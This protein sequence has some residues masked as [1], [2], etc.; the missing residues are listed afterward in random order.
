MADRTPNGGKSGTQ[1]NTIASELDREVHRSH[2]NR[3]REEVEEVGLDAETADHAAQNT[4]YAGYDSPEFESGDRVSN[5]GGEGP[6]D[7]TLV[8]EDVDARETDIDPVGYVP[9]DHARRGGEL[10]S[11]AGAEAQRASAGRDGQPT[12]GEAPATTSDTPTNGAAGAPGAQNADPAFVPGTGTEP[13]LFLVPT[14]AGNGSNQESSATPANGTDS[15][16]DSE[17][18]S[19]NGGGLVVRDADYEISESSADGA[20]VGAVVA[21][22]GAGPGQVTFGLADDADGRF[23]IDPVSGQVFV[24]D[25][26]LLDYEASDSHEIVVIASLPDGSSTSASFEVRITDDTSESSVSEISDVDTGSNTIGENAAPGTSTGIVVGAVDGDLSDSIEYGLSDDADGAFT[27]DPESG[28]IFVADPSLIDAE[29][30]PTV[31]IEVT[32]TSSDGS[33]TSRTFEIAVEDENEFD[34]TPVVDSGAAPNEIAETASAGDPVGVTGVATDAD[35]TDSN[36]TYSLTE[37]PNDA[38]AIDAETGE[39]TVAD[40]SGLDF[41]SAQSMQIEVTATSEDGSTSSQTFDIAVTD[42]NEFDVSAVTDSDVAADSVSESA[43]AGDSVGVTAFAADADGSNDGVT[44]S[45]SENP[46]DAFAIDADTGEVTVADP[47]GLDFES[48]QSMQIEVTATSEDG[49]SSTQSFDIAVTDSNEFDVSAVSDGD[50]AANSV[51]ENAEA[52]DSVGVTAFASDNDGSSNGVTYSLSENPND[53]FAIDS[54]TGEV[55]VAD[56]SGLDF[57]SAQSMQIEV[58]ATSEDGSTSSQTFDIAVTDNNEF[59]VSAVSD[60]DAGA[61]TVSEGAAAGDSVGVTAFASDDDGSSNGVT[62]SLSE[63]PN[64]AFAIDAETGE[65]TVADPN[66]LDFESAQ[67]MQIEVTATSEDGSSSTQS[68]DIAVTDSN[69]FDVSAVSDGDAGAD[70]VSEGAPPVTASA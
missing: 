13:T 60:G 37:N 48:A 52:G 9:I 42:S 15:G 1:S 29:S 27:I 21:V 67:S 65:V 25:P 30:S 26:E 33:V 45:L 18:G 35:S 3:R 16:T 28:E 47:S 51:A 20:S 59:D 55:T 50:A 49:S 22:N 4:G 31:S 54:E 61:D 38:F 70:S 23:G 56:P 41:E 5:E 57:E 66:A 14:P 2:S 63:N 7:S 62:Y 11:E 24:R 69:E 53:A 39:V 43:S 12:G 58:T 64:D 34:V 36:V 32:A 40:P 19:G 6:V 10:P 8:N 46:N 17:Y 44:Y 68:F